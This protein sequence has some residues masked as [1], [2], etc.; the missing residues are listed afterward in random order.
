MGVDNVVKYHAATI[1]P[2]NPSKS[3]FYWIQDH[4][5][6]MKLRLLEDRKSLEH[7]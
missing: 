1:S 2:G 5:E 7:S 4:Q 6:T 3:I